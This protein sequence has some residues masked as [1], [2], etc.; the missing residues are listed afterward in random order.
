M[1][2]GQGIDG[3]VSLRRVRRTIAGAVPDL[4][5][6]QEVDRLVWRSGFVPQDAWLGLSLKMYRAFGPAIRWRGF[7][8]FGNAI[9]SGRPLLGAV[10]YSLPG[11]GERRGL[12]VAR[13]PDF[14]LACTH[15]GLDAG[16]R[17]EQVAAILEILRRYDGPLILA[18]DFNCR[19]EDPELEE[20]H[21]FLRDTAP[22]ALPYTYPAERPSVKADYIFVSPHFTCH[23]LYA[24][25]SPASDHL[26]LCADLE[27]V[28]LEDCGLI[29]QKASLGAF[30]TE[31]PGELGESAFFDT[32]DIAPGNTQLAGYFLLGTL[33][34]VDQAETQGDDFLLPPR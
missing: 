21:S 1:R 15:L 7:T 24:P 23:S 26:P 33:S 4:V 14:T 10:N 25:H 18:G 27:V 29:G 13:R 9:L 17:R 32:G 34:T 11:K 6:L 2:H 28:L 8:A 16:E 31:F 19:R 20:L 3:R 12:L 30:Q 22:D 5:A